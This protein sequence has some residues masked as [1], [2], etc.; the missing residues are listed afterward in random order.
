MMSMQ[1][2]SH[3]GTAALGC[4]AAQVYPAAVC[5]SQNKRKMSFEGTAQLDIARN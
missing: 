4:P 3:V 2:E 5:Q 1:W